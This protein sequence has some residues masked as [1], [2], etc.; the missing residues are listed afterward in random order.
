M[1]VRCY[2]R[3]LE[4]R[5]KAEAA[6]RR[7]AAKE[8]AERRLAEIEEQE[9]LEAERKLQEERWETERIRDIKLAEIEK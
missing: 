7:R 2:V 8:E 5:W 3:L 6:E 4:E 1:Y 9:R